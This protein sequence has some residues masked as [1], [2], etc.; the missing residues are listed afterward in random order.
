V[1]GIR[2]GVRHDKDV[3]R[4]MLP[5]VL[6]RAQMFYRYLRRLRAIGGPRR[7]PAKR[8][9]PAGRPASGSSLPARLALQFQ[10]IDQAI[11]SSVPTVVC[12]KAV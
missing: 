5:R 12:R 9:V 10:H 11:A 8:R 2:G 7:D 4:Q 1:L 3:M 6:P